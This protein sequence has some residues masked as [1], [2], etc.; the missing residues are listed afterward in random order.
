[1]LERSL[2]WLLDYMAR[3]PQPDEFAAPVYGAVLDVLAYGEARGPA[4]RRLAL[5]VMG[6]LLAGGPTASQY[7]E[8]LGLINHMWD[9][10]IR[11]STTLDWLVDVLVLITE[12]PCPSPASRLQLM[13]RGLSEAVT[14]RDVDPL[15]VE[16]LRGLAIDA[17]YDGRCAAEVAALPAPTQPEP[18][19]PARS[20]GNHLLIGIYSLSDS[21]VHRAKAVLEQRFPQHVVETNNELDA[22]PR[23]E[24]LAQRADVMAMVIASAKHAAT[25]AIR[26]ACPP[27]ALLE[28]GTAGSTGL[29]RAI[30]GRLE[31][32]SAV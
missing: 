7:E 3:R 15:T 32:L 1:L 4:V 13:G 28:V 25:N 12:Q 30:V 29:L 11:S 24:A 10:G 19:D 21:A 20:P 22:S 6:S 18:I 5:S 27:A 2:T 16:L 9:D 17:V 26:K 23:L 31:E 8:Y 14:L